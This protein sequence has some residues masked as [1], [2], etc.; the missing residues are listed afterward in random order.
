MSLKLDYN[1]NDI[2]TIHHW[3]SP[4]N[5][6]PHTYYFMGEEETQKDKHKNNNA[7]TN[8]STKINKHIF[9]DDTINTILNKVSHYIGNKF[10]STE[11]NPNDYYIWCE[12]RVNKTDIYVF[13]NT[14]F[15][16]IS[17]YEPSKLNVYCKIYFDI[18]IDIFNDK[19][20]D[21]YSMINYDDALNTLLEKIEK[22]TL[23][24]YIN[25][26]FNLNNN[27]ILNNP[28]KYNKVDQ[29]IYNNNEITSL[30]HNMISN[31]DVKENNEIN[32]N[33]ITKEFF[34]NVDKN[35]TDFT[36]YFFPNVV[37]TINQD[38]IQTIDNTI[39]QIQL[40]TNPKLERNHKTLPSNSS[41]SNVSI[42]D[43]STSPYYNTSLNLKQ[44]FN[45]FETTLK[46]PMIIYKNL[47]NYTLKINK[48]YFHKLSSEEVSNLTKTYKERTKKNAHYIQFYIIVNNITIDIKVHDFGLVDY[49][50]NIKKNQSISS[51][52]IANTFKYLK[53]LKLIQNIHV[54][55]YELTESTN[56]FTDAFIKVNKYNIINDLI[57][58]DTIKTKDINNSLKK[59]VGVFSYNNFISHQD[60][61]SRKY[62]VL[63]LQYN[64]D[65]TIRFM[66]KNKSLNNLLNKT[67]TFVR[68][69]FLN[70]YQVS[71]EVINIINEYTNID[72]VKAC[73]CLLTN[74]VKDL[75]D[76]E[77]SNVKKEYADLQLAHNQM[78][79]ES[80]KNQNKTKNKEEDENKNENG[81]EK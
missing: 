63:I 21:K 1:N 31:F 7:K 29:I 59:L 11:P 20:L 50:Y 41:R 51:N 44:I 5:T 66:T 70:I 52:D 65:S 33:I 36:K 19:M 74:T 71:I 23:Y 64:R 10:G 17:H 76:V 78:I 38:V 3:T 45:T 16:N 18:N 81:D 32:I 68:I 55:L 62:Q 40:N 79:N 47:T 60:I 9:N 37:S 22:H 6:K 26:I 43:F 54:D 48:E 12:K 75:S 58:K 28:F 80:Y 27:Q 77:L 57:F 72:I 67:Q 13:L 69:T 24:C 34:D 56:L 73:I 49:C 39:M 42:L 15:H 8:D 30:T 35:I 53:D 14:I 2:F 61:T 25:L 4:T 46:I